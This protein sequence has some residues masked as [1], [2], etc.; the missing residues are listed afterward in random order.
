M[1]LWRHKH[2]KPLI[3]DY[4]SLSSSHYGWLLKPTQAH[5]HTH[6]NTYILIMGWFPWR[7]NLD[8]KSLQRD[9]RFERTDSFRKPKPCSE[10]IF[11][12][13]RAVWRATACLCCCV[14]LPARQPRLFEYTS[15][16]TRCITP[17]WMP[18]SVDTRVRELS[19]VSE[20]TLRPCPVHSAV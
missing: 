5:T 14:A 12:S 9:P 7:Q 18:F 4:S 15:V 6:F 13:Q 10:C 1:L 3:Q 17:V 8:S 20:P 16:S 11:N 2:F 19:R